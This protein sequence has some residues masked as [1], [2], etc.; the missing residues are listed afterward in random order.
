MITI[1]GFHHSFKGRKIF[2]GLDWSIKKN[3]KY[4]LVGP[5]GTGKTTLLE[6]ISG[7]LDTESGSVIIPKK[8][9]IGYLS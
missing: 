1:S 7:S 8:I 3:K 6:A 5:N 9:V 2:D 4:G